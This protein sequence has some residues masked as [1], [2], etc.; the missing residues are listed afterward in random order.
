MYPRWYFPF[1]LGLLFYRDDEVPS[2]FSE[3]SIIPSLGI[4]SLGIPS[5]GI[6]SL[7]IPS[8]GHYCFNIK[9]RIIDESV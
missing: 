8:L 3:R 5:L 2:S 9:F 4:P 1:D 7:G 6:P